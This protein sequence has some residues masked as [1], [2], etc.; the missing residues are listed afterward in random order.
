MDSLPFACLPACG[1]A[2]IIALSFLE[3]VAPAQPSCTLFLLRGLATVD[4]TGDL[5]RTA[6]AS[7]VGCVSGA[8]CW[9]TVGRL[10]GG[11]RCER[12][13][14]RLGKYLLL[15]PD[16]YRRLAAACSRHHFRVTAVSQTVPTARIYLALPAGVIGLAFLPFLVATSPGTLA[17]NAP[18][19]TPGYLLRGTGWSLAATGLAFTAIVVAIEAAVV[20]MVARVRN[21]RPGGDLA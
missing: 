17:W 13:V 2:G 14:H 5:G 6:L 15:S 3:K 11:A 12:L 1:L 19:I 4:D 8:V 21:Q 10:V 9:Y 16:R 18:L 7:T 20:V